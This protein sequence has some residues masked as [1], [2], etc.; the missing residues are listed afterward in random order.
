MQ[1]SS[2]RDEHVQIVWENIESG[3]ENN[4]IK[5]EDT[6][7]T[8]FGEQYDYG[9]VMHYSARAF[10]VNGEYTIIPIDEQVNTINGYFLT[11]YFNCF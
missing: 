4:F 6:V 11:S 2:E 5:R 7:I 8:N 1:S 3:K 10:S 9:S